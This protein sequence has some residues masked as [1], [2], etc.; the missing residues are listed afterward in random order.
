MGCTCDGQLSSWRRPCEAFAARAVRCPATPHLVHALW[1]LAQLRLQGLHHAVHSGVCDGEEGAVR[2]GAP[3]PCKVGHEEPAP[4]H[5]V[6]ENNL[7]PAQHDPTSH[8]PQA[9]RGWMRSSSGCDAARPRAQRTQAA[10]DDGVG[11]A[12]RLAQQ[13]RQRLRQHNLALQGLNG[14]QPWAAGDA[15]GLQ[16]RGTLPPWARWSHG[17]SRRPHG[18]RARRCPPLLAPLL[19]PHTSTRSC[20]AALKSEGVTADSTAMGTMPPVHATMWSCQCG[21]VETHA[22]E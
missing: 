11:G 1:F 12:L 22:R 3:H 14:E 4:L 5:F 8:Q 2:H 18:R 16:A 21:V 10:G 17:S 13:R 7:M 9:C 15:E 19:H 20:I 6:Q